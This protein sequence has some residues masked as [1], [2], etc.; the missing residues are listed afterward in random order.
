MA[1]YEA[2]SEHVFGGFKP[3][4]MKKLGIGADLG[5]LSKEGPSPRSD[6][7]AFSPKSGLQKK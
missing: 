2:E 6:P 1:G 3:K 7:V 5:C 4:G